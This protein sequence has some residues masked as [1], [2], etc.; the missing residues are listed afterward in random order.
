MIFSTMTRE[1]KK[2]LNRW[3]LGFGG[4][5]LIAG[6]IPGLLPWQLGIVLFVFCLVAVG[7]IT[8]IIPEPEPQEH[9]PTGESHVDQVLQRPADENQDKTGTS[10]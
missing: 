3:I 8:I 10:V 9:Q 5:A 6:F 4:L 7:I 2:R 1:R